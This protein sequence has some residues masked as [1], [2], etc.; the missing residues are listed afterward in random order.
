MISDANDYLDDTTTTLYP[1]Y[2]SENTASV[3]M[4]EEMM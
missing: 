1:Y 2:L 4:E 3:E